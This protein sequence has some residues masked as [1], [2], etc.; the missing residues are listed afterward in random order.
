[1]GNGARLAIENSGSITLP[2]FSSSLHLK[3]VLH[4]PN[5]SANLLS[6]QRFSLDNAC[7]FI[8]TLSH[9][10]VKDL[11]T[12]AILLEGKSE[13][14][15]YPLQL[16]MNSLRG[17]WA[18]TALSG[19]RTSSLVWHFK[20]G[21]SSFDVVSCVVKHNHLPPYCN[22]FNKNVVCTS[23]QLGKSKR[24]SFH[25]STHLS[26]IPLQL[27]HIN[28]WTSPVQFMSGCKYYVVFIDDFSHYTWLYPLYKKS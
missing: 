6:I 5:A 7:Y 4:C 9:Y 26:T 8:F 19:I 10:F 11:R 23:C 28:I 20:L 3:N 21:H 27:V 1:M 14:G 22:D 2:S 13:N 25:S 15:L 17:N 24:K 12:R 16:Q 18:F